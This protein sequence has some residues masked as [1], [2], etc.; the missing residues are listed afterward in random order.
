M[1]AGSDE[2]CGRRYRTHNPFT[3]SPMRASNALP[4]NVHADPVYADIALRSQLRQQLLSLPFDGFARVVSRLLQKLGYE[5]VRSAGRRS[6]RGRNQHTGGA[7]AG[8]DLAASMPAPDID[9]YAQPRTVVV[10]LKQY[11]QA[12]RVWQKQVDGLRGAALRVGAQEALLITT[13]SFS[14]SVIESQNAG[15]PANTDA[16][17]LIPGRRAGDL[18]APV[19]LVDGETLLS[20]LIANRIGVTAQTATAQASAPMLEE[21]KYKIEIEDIG[22]EAAMHLDEGFFA[23]VRAASRGNG[24]SDRPREGQVENRRGGKRGS[25]WQL[26]IDLKP[27]P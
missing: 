18:V 4:V 17:A 15:G 7:F 13:S 26:T 24:P 9:G 12:T 20:L 25:S 2:R 10:A 1:V 11:P 8:F 3:Y 19:R 14:P 21:Q 23:R 22:G 27:R 5:R 6:F 16:I